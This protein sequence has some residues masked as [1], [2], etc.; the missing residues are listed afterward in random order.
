MGPS[1]LAFCKGLQTSD[2]FHN[3][4]AAQRPLAVSNL[5]QEWMKFRALELASGSSPGSSVA[6]MTSGK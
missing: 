3:Y 6:L 5:K 2:N 1:Q 4:C